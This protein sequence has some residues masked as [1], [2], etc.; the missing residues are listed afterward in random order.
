MS[1]AE[2]K[3]AIEDIVDSFSAR[4][5]TGQRPSIEEYKQK[6]PQ[7]ADRIEAVLPALVALENID[8]DAGGERKLA[9]DR[10]HP[11]NPGGLP[12]Y[13]GGWS[14]RYG[15]RVRST[16]YDHATAGGIKSSTEKFC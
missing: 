16:T 11:G 12:D 13:S 1:A 15:D 6:Y 10:L 5:E 7:L 9:V 4:L 14:G 2:N 3:K 8:S